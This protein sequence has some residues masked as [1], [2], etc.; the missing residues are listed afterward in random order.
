[1][2][3]DKTLME[4]LMKIL[5]EKLWI[6]L[7][8]KTSEYDSTLLPDQRIGNEYLAGIKSICKFG[9]E[10]ASTIRDTFPLFTLHDETHIC[11]VMRLMLDLIDDDT[12]K[13][14]RD[15]VAMLILAAC[16]HDIGMSYSTDDKN[17]LFNDVDRLNKYLDEHHGEY[18]K[19]YSSGDSEPKMTPEMIQNYLRSIHH[20]RIIDLL[21]NYEWPSV[22]KGKVDCHHLVY[23]CQSHGKDVSLLDEL[24]KTNSIDLRF[25]AIL[26]RLADVLDFDTSRAPE[27]VYEYSGF[28]NNDLEIAKSKEEWNKHIS[29]HGFDFRN[30]SDR[31][32]PYLLDYNATCKSMQVE[33]AVNSYLD[34]VDNELAGCARQ[35]KRF[36]GKWQDIVL[37]RKVK[38]NI[39]SEGY[40]SGQFHLTMDQNRIVDLLVGNGLYND[41]FVFVRELVQNSI[42]AVRTREKLDKELPQSWKPQINIRCWM[43]DEGYHWFR[44]EDNGIGMTENII[45]NFFLKIGCSYYTS[46]TFNQAK[47]RCKADL[48]YVPISRFGIGILSCFMDDMLTSQVEISTKHFNEKGKYYPALRLRMHRTNG[49]Y[50]LA[51][52]DK[53]HMPGHMKGVTQKEKEPY[54]KQAGTVIAVRTNLLKM[55][56]Y[57]GFKEIVDRYITYPY[58]SIHFDGEEGSFDYPTESDFLMDMKTINTKDDI[59]NKEMM[60]FKL[61][62]KHLKEVKDE[63]PNIV[64][65]KQPKL[66]LKN[67]FL[68]DYT[69]SEFL[70]GV[71]LVAKVISEQEPIVFQFD[72]CMEKANVKAEI[73]THT[74][75]EVKI[76]IKL[77]VVFTENFKQRMALI[78]EKYSK[79]RYSYYEILTKIYDDGDF[80]KD[81]A[82]LVTFDHAFDST[83]KNTLKKKYKTTVTK[84][85]SGYAEVKEKF[86]QILTSVEYDEENTTFSEREDIATFRKFAEIKK[87]WNFWVC[88]LSEYDWFVKY[89]YAKNKMNKGVLANITSHNGVFCD[90]ADYLLNSKVKSNL[91]S[92]VLLKDK[93]R[94]DMDI[95]RNSIRNFDLETTAELMFIKKSLCDEGFDFFDDVSKLDKD[96]FRFLSMKRFY[97]LIEE[98]DDYK[99]KLKFETDKGSFSHNELHEQLNEH[100]KL[101]LINIPSLKYWSLNKG[102][103]FL[104]DSIYMSFLQYKYSLRVDMSQNVC[105]VYIFPKNNETLD[106]Y[107][108]FFPPFFFA[109]PLDPN[110]TYIRLNS[111]SSACA[112]NANHRF[113]LWLQQNYIALNNRMPGIYTE[114]L[115]ILKDEWW[116]SQIKKINDLLDNIRR[117]PGSPI[118]V[119]DKIYLSKEDFI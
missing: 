42:D 29:S 87:E 113:S 62:N 15:E 22:L 110:C 46:D 112:C 75:D 93:Y 32:Y 19:A 96:S 74:F 98:R 67:I 90:N 88:N 68:N 3:E 47:I 63:L 21:G 66:V 99:A 52:K 72:N 78:Q 17:E 45:M 94:P 1:M 81:L 35:L 83:W 51:S 58:V 31:S 10:R 24:E 54:L 65:N 25:C 61:S 115:R 33:Q 82:Y 12:D 92:I 57:K 95:A 36:T 9:I 79:N 41:P 76:G 13:I 114:L 64:F 53:N 84:L 8:N 89:F 105:D 48:D 97:D 14:S 117:L 44:I 37:P 30:I 5:N 69:K 102:F 118:N 16:C 50:Y 43:D 2:L 27:S 101:K 28:N 73:I 100:K 91:G 108:Y 85:N 56:E 86:N 119:P 18:V 107:E 34:W 40:V 59:K 80:R 109:V 20:E 38:R 111:P 49:Y 6:I 71:V 39:I 70:S 104:Y 55:G 103:S 23:V 60:E 4:A 7:E 11:N 77:S 26:L 116:G 106:D